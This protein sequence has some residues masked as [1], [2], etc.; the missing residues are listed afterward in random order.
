VKPVKSSYRHRGMGCNAERPIRAGR[1]T[2]VGES[3]SFLKT[4]IMLGM[5][6]RATG[7]R[8]FGGGRNSKRR[9]MRVVHAPGGRCVVNGSRPNTCPPLGD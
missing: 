5:Q 6:R 2:P 9:G 8:G 4:L 7:G 3:V 1:Q